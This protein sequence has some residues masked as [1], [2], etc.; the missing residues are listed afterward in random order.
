M[1]DEGRQLVEQGGV[2]RGGELSQKRLVRAL[3]EPFAH[4]DADD[5]VHQE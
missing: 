3:L 1:T 4:D 2:I 5:I